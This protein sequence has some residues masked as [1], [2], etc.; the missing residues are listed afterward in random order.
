MPRSRYAHE[1]VICALRQTFGERLRMLRKQRGWELD[2]LAVRIGM[3]K[4]SVSRIELGKQNLSI[5]DIGAI[6]GA[7]EVSPADLFGVHGPEG[8]DALRQMVTN[9]KR[10]LD[11]IAAIVYGCKQECEIASVAV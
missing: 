11:S 7:L 8:E 5:D 6:A 2:D 1:D 10:S 3:T 9:W 4:T